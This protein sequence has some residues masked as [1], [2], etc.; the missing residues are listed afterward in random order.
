MPQPPNPST[1]VS[2][3][4]AI[5]AARGDGLHPRLLEAL[6]KSGRVSG[7]PKPSEHCDDNVVQASFGNPKPAYGGTKAQS[8]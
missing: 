6:A 1:T 5:A 2:A 3:F 4:H 7:P 8:R